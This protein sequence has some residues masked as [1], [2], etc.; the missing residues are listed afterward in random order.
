[1]HELQLFTYPVNGSEGDGHVHTFQGH[2]LID[3]RHFHRLQGTTGPALGLPNGDHYH[4]INS[5][6][7][8]EPFAFRGG[9]YTTLLAVKR[10]TH[11]F[12]GATS[13]G[14]GYADWL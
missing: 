7:I 14:L 9:Y 3:G 8:N 13:T 2:T 1:M 5:E 12:H 6:T 11:T 4:L 10:H